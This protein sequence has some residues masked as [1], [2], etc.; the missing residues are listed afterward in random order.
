MPKFFKT[1]ILRPGAQKSIGA[2]RTA[3]SHWPNQIAKS[4]CCCCCCNSCFYCCC[5]CRR[6]LRKTSKRL[7]HHSQ[8]NVPPPS[9]TACAPQTPNCYNECLVTFIAA[10]AIVVACSIPVTTATMH[11][12]LLTHTLVRMKSYT[13]MAHIGNTP[14]SNCQMVEGE[15]S[16][17]EKV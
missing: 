10:V 9:I 11:I 2:Q 14:R 12:H 16:G 3:F 17:V 1:E 5:C 6:I 15:M 13:P 7:G 4:A 8:L